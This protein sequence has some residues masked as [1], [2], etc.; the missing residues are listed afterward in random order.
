MKW[1]LLPNDPIRVC[2]RTNPYPNTAFGDVACLSRGVFIGLGVPTWWHA[3]AAM[4]KW[5]CLKRRHQWLTRLDDHACNELLMSSKCSCVRLGFAINIL[6]N[7]WLIT[8]STQ[9]QLHSGS[10]ADLT[11]RFE[12]KCGGLRIAHT[13]TRLTLL[14]CGRGRSRLDLCIN[15]PQ[16]M[17][18][19]LCLSQTTNYSPE[20]AA[21]INIG[22]IL[23][24]LRHS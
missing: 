11:R 18:S 12:A 20:P 10:L 17:V 14:Y 4:S 21:F 23:F 24:L 3:W 19:G 13:D 2:S 7:R 1:N 6:V 8:S 15:E 22:L 5:I 9:V 16:R